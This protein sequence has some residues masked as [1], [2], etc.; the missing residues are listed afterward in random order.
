MANQYGL[1]WNSVSSDRLYD[2]DSF[3]EWLKKFFTTGVFNG[4]LQ[5]LAAS[6]MDVTVQTG[7]AN[8]EG[9]VR[10]FDTAT[11]FTLAPASGTYPRIDTIVVERNDTDREITVKYVQGTY[12]GN[13]PTPTA[14]VRA[15]GVY[16]IVLAQIYVAVGATEIVQGNITDTR[17]DNTLCGWVVGTVDR[18]DVEQMTAQVQDEME[19]WFEGM[20]DQLSEDA[21]I[22]LQ[23]Q[24]G[25]L[26]QLT[27]TVQTDL[28]SAINEVNSVIETPI[29]LAAASWVSGIYTITDA[30]I[31]PAKEIILAYDPTLTDAEYKAYQKANIRPWG[32]VSAGSMQL[33]AVGGAPSVDLGMILIVR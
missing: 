20:K 14:P 28:V 29:T 9:K 3:S 19:T 30:S 6:G 31:D 22:N 21:A 2:A 8:I 7:Y 17:A 15:A 11:T 4:D 18:V 1:F 16:Q 5:V 24:I 23:N 27:T 13:T 32:T 25:T 26:S 12:S 10:F 33:K